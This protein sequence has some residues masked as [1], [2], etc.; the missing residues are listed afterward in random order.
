MTHPLRPLGAFLLVFACL[1]GIA[2]AQATTQT[3]A[4]DK[5][6]DMKKLLAEI[7]GDYS[8]EFQAQVLLVQFTAQDDRLFGAPPGEMPEEIKPVEG[9]PLC[10]DV[11]V[12]TTGDY[13]VLQ[14]VRNDQGVIDKCV[15]TVQ[16]M[17][18]EGYKV[19]K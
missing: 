6:V 4:Q 1:V 2:S 15:M 10:F 11:T 7:A 16:G 18:I 5:P 14:F 19:A 8:F 9:E 12:S 3:A 17:V 13:Y